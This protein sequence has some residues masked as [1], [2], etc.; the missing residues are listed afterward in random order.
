MEEGEKEEDGVRESG[1]GRG[2]GERKREGLGREEE[3]GLREEKW[4]GRARGVEV[5]EEEQLQKSPVALQKATNSL[6]TCRQSLPN[7]LHET[8]RADQTESRPSLTMAT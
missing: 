6:T 1:R 2:Q 4:W 5:R 7:C 8:C 3:G